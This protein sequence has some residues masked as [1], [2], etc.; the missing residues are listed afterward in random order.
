MLPGIDFQ[1]FQARREAFEFIVDRLLRADGYVIE[2]GTAWD[3][4]NFEGQGQSTLVWDRCAA[5][6]PNLGVISIDK[7]QTAIDTASAQTALVRYICGD[8][9]AELGGLANSRIARDAVLL[10][11]DSFDWHPTLN[12]ESSHHHLCELAAVYS[13]LPAGCMIAVDDCHGPLEGKHWMVEHFFLKLGINPVIKS[14]VTV[15]IKPASFNF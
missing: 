4:D 11:L 3:K 9:V 8:S 2:T 14:Y 6:N 5:Q 12:L 10:Y 7:N 13:S 1:R 15:W